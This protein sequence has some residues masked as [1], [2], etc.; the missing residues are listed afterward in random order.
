MINED[1]WVNSV[2]K[3]NVKFE[4]GSAQI[5]HNRWINTISKKNNYNSIKK[6][7]FK[8]YTL[9]CVVFVFGLFFVSIVKNETRNLQKEINDLQASINV[10]KFDFNQ[11]VID[12]EVITSPENISKL[13]KENLITDF[14]TYKKS[15]IK[16]LDEKEEA[17]AKEEKKKDLVVSIKSQVKKKILQKKTEIRKLQELYSNP[18][19]IPAELKNKVAKQIKEKKIELKKIYES[20]NEVITMEKVQRWGAIQVVKV[21]LGIPIVPGK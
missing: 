3:Y 6:Y 4:E 1:K 11:A 15:Q 13:A 21:F 14:E 12:N 16:S 2:S 10:I 20:P 18:K 5:D 8:K 19:S 9:M 17:S 7:T